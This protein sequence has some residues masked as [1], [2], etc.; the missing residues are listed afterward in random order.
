MQKKENM[1]RKNLIILTFLIGILYSCDNNQKLKKVEFLF[2]PSFLNIT[3]FTIDIENKTIEEY[4]SQTSYTEYKKNEENQIKEITKD[5]LI[6]HY[7]KTFKI[8]NENLQDFLNELE[9]SQLN[10]SLKHGE[11]CLD[12]VGFRI[13]KINMK[14]D[15]ISL[16]TSNPLRN[17][18]YKTDFKILDAFFKLSYKTIN[19]YKGI[20][21]VENIQDYF[22]Y[23]LP[24]RLVN[25][26]PLE[27]RVWGSVS[28]CREDNQK[29]IAFFNKLP[30]NKPVL[31]DLRNGSFSICLY[32]VLGDFSKKKQLYFYG[33][34][35]TLEYKK[36]IEKQKTEIE[37]AKKNNKDY[38]HLEE[39]YKDNL[40]NYKESISVNKLL[41][42]NIKFYFTKEEIL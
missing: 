42:K 15:T 19:D 27:Y 32:E 30:N 21:I 12:G 31:F 11:K 39:Q 20:C 41:N 26:N 17:N 13:S 22:N 3:K 16:T 23:G 34:N 2:A 28:G 10:K 9:L 1:K 25:K 33:K 37:D 6:V 8:S 29:L 14:N 35:E 7:K 36:I 5:T 18:K 4:S 40:W 38:S 24:I